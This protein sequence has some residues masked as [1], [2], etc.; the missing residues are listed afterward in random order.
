MTR[1]LRDPT[2]STLIHSEDR[3]DFGS[4]TTHCGRHFTSHSIDKV[5]DTAADKYCEKCYVAREK[6]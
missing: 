5:R 2:V 3:R 6:R 1:W 4:V